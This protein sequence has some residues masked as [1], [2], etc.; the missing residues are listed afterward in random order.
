MFLEQEKHIE[1]K[2]EEKFKQNTYRTSK[3]DFGR[4]G[5][6]VPFP[7]CRNGRKIDRS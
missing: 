4:I 6:L 1:T 2:V 5:R 3:T 7:V